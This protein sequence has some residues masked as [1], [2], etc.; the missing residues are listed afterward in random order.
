M[1]PPEQGSFDKA[2]ISCYEK[3]CKEYKPEGTTPFAANQDLWR[4]CWKDANVGLVIDRR[5][6]PPKE[7]FVY[8]PARYNPYQWRIV[9]Q[10][11]SVSN[12]RDIYYAVAIDTFPYVADVTSE[13]IRTVIRKFN[14]AITTD[15][16]IEHQWINQSD[17]YPDEDG[18]MLLPN[19]K[20]LPGS[21]KT[22]NRNKR[23]FDDMVNAEQN[24]LRRST[25]KR[26]L[27]IN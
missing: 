10:N 13:F 6:A 24:N 7:Q 2:N 12:D 17:L 19:W 18:G 1:W 3:S 8:N 14:A 9:Y 26:K 22:K 27:F 25:R 20:I 23:R 21:P 4:W 16:Q 5:P 15:E 11:P